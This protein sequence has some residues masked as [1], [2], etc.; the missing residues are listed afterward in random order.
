MKGSFEE[1]LGIQSPC[2]RMIGVSNHLLSKV[3]RFQ[4]H[5]QKVIGSRGSLGKQNEGITDNY[6]RNLLNGSDPLLNETGP[7]GFGPIQF[8]ME[9]GHIGK[10]QFPCLITLSV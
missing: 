10:T 1:T 3:F 7:L 6:P 8:L 4:Y 2:Q 5:Y 9:T